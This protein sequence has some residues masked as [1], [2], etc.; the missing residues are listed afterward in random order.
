MH[1]AI[2]TVD[3]DLFLSVCGQYLPLMDAPQRG[4]GTHTPSISKR[5]TTD[6]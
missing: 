1:D 6:S 5:F 2:S 3:R 4:L